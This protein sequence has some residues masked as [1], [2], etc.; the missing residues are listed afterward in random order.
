MPHVHTSLGPS[1]GAWKFRQKGTIL[2]VMGVGVHVRT[3]SV[4]QLCGILCDPMDCS[5]PGSSVHGIS[6][7]RIL[8]WLAIPSSRGS[9][10]PRTE[11]ASLRPLHCKWILYSW[12]TVEAPWCPHPI[13]NTPPDV[14]ATERGSPSQL[15]SR[16]ETQEGTPIQPDS[17]KLWIWAFAASFPAAWNEEK[18][19]SVWLHNYFSRHAFLSFQGLQRLCFRTWDSRC[20][21]L[22]EGTGLPWWS[23]G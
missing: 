17:Q 3:C 8:E 15:L 14:S 19:I 6:Q 7:S 9:C 5:P 22:K 10:Q 2:A 1:G 13:L 18:H 16:F 20:K 23:S 21:I 11:P 12:G 4:A